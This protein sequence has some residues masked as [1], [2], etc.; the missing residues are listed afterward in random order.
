[1]AMGPAR[2]AMRIAILA[3]ALAAVAGDLPDIE[4]RKQLIDMATIIEQESEELSASLEF[5]DGQLTVDE[6]LPHA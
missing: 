2:R 3:G 6:R 1:M 4:L 5:T